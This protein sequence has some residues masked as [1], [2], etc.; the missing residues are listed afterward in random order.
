MRKHL[1][2]EELLDIYIQTV[3]NNHIHNPV[4]TRT[5]FH[6]LM[7]SPSHTQ[8]DI[9]KSNAL[10][11]TFTEFF[12]F[13]LYGILC[14]PSSRLSSTFCNLKSKAHCLLIS[15][16]PRLTTI[17]ICLKLQRKSKSFHS[18]R[19]SSSF[20]FSLSLSLT[21]SSTWSL[22]LFLGSSRGTQ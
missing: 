5:A 14:L 11:M 8:I 17:I 13:L 1:H 15:L 2:F 6:N 7:T 21:A 22:A 4:L 20:N 10:T 3:S 9:S 12:G 16:L 19:G 18:T